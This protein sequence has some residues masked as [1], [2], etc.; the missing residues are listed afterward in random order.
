MFINDP[1]LETIIDGVYIY[2]NFIPA[3]LVAKI[4]GI[5]N[6]RVNIGLDE[7]NSLIPW[8]RDKS[9]SEIPQLYEVWELMSK[10]LLPTH[11]IHPMLHLNI[12]RPGDGEMFVHEDSPGEGNEHT[13]TNVDRW[14]T[15]CLLDYGVITYFGEFTGGETFY[16][17]LG[18]EVAPQPGDMIIHGAHSKHKHGVREVTSGIRYAFSN[19]SLKPEKNP[20]TF[21]NYG[22]KEH[23]E[24]LSKGLDKWMTPYIHNDREYAKLED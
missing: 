11:V 7:F 18:V 21:S 17:E 3:K 1:N 2:R 14:S 8:Y 12:M 19:F 24:Q 4:N 22:T 16:P 9:T 13:L 23:E 6:D 15:C 5:A 10:F 20:G